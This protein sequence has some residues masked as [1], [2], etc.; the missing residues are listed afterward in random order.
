MP[1]AAAGAEYAAG[2]M[3]A[4]ALLHAV[5]IGLRKIDTL[6]WHRTAQVSIGGDCRF[7]SGFAENAVGGFRRMG[8]FAARNG[9]LSDDQCFRLLGRLWTLKRL[10]YYVYGGWAQGINLNEYPPAVAYLFGK[11]IY[12]ESTHEMQFADEILRR[13]FVRTQKQLFA[14]PHSQFR[15]ATRTGAYIFCLRALA[16]YPQNIRLAALNLGPKVVELAW[17]ERFARELPDEALHALFQSQLA[18]TR[19]HVLMG[20]LQVERFVQKA[21]DIEL[22]KRLCAETRRDYLFFLEETARF[23]LGLEE[24]K[25]GEVMVPADID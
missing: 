1:F 15:T 3:L 20:R 13:R 18:E 21:V 5:G 16:N 12:D 8:I 6:Y 4:T 24:E 23:V 22:A 25:A 2:F 9:K 11:Q 7:K 14:H 10:M 19:S 17:T